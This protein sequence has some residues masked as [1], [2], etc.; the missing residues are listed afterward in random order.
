VA[1]LAVAVVLT[2]TS[3]YE[4]APIADHAMRRGGPK[5]EVSAGSPSMLVAFLSASSG[6]SRSRRD[7]LLERVEHSRSAD[8]LI[9][10]HRV[11]D[12]SREPVTESRAR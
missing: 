10:G 6:R 7:E 2:I 12:R 9:S 8:V 5:R 3:G 11:A 4:F 1:M